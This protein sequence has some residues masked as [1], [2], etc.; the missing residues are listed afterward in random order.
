MLI[1]YR[2]FHQE[3]VAALVP[4]VAGIILGRISG[5][6]ASKNDLNIVYENNCFQKLCSGDE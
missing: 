2:R 6:K 5:E 3:S 1:L 4:G